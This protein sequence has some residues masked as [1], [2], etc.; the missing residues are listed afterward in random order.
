VTRRLWLVGF[1]FG[2]IHGFGFAGALGE[3]GLPDRAR[4]SALLGFNLGV[5]LGQIAVVAAALPLIVI[6]RGKRWYAKV[7]MPLASLAIAALAGVWLWQRLS[8]QA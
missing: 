7:A 5:E 2:L 1:V 8:G 6:A 4:L 3:L